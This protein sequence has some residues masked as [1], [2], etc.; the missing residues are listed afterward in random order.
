V[1]SGLTCLTTDYRTYAKDDYRNHKSYLAVVCLLLVVQVFG[2]IVYTT[3]VWLGLVS[4][5]RL[6]DFLVVNARLK[7]VATHLLCGITVGHMFFVHRWV[8]VPLVRV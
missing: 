3:W 1:C 7:A 8:S 6:F 5:V 2:L 4:R